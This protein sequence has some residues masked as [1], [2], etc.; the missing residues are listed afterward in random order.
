MNLIAIVIMASTM[1]LVTSVNAY[2]FM[3]VLRTPPQPEPD[4]YDKNDDI[5]R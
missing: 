2:F 5:P 1:L 4:S 3:K